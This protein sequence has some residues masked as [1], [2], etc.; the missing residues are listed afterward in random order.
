MTARSKQILKDYFCSGGSAKHSIST[1]EQELEDLIDT[2]YGAETDYQ[3]TSTI[4]GWTS[5]IDK[6]IVY[7]L[8]GN[9]VFVSFHISGTSNSVDTTFTLPYAASAT[10]VDPIQMLFRIK[11]NNSSATGYG[12]LPAGSSTFDVSPDLDGSNWT[13]S[14]TKLIIGQFWYIK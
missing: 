9:K 7:I 8:D 6:Q 5:F 13:S 2:F 4:V 12:S 11:D 10:F 14:G 3:D 1:M